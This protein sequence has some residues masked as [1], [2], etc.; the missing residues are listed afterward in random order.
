MKAGAEGHLSLGPLGFTWSFLALKLPDQAW[1]QKGCGLA[2]GF[3]GFQVRGTRSCY[4]KPPTNTPDP[5][6]FPFQGR[7]QPRKWQLH[8]PCPAISEAKCMEAEPITGLHLSGHKCRNWGILG[9][10]QAGQAHG[11][12]PLSAHGLK[13]GSP[14]PGSAREC[15]HRD[16]SARRRQLTWL[17]LPS[18]SPI[19]V[20]TVSEKTIC[21]VR[22]FVIYRRTGTVS[23]K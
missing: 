8:L 12:S 14:L 16:A 22:L 1:D 3:R 2:S 11:S 15:V 20:M 5:S 21:P 17:L 4:Q 9:R 7:E 23:V 18:S 10:Y 19:D 6:V 13:P